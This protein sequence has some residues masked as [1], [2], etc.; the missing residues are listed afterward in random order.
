MSRKSPRYGRLG[1]SRWP[2]TGATFILV[3]KDQKNPETAKSV[4]KFFDWCYKNGQETAKQK[5]YVPM[6][7]SVVKMVEETWSKD[8]TSGGKP[9]WP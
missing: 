7:E 8:V 3:F 5:D 2:I 9:I 4:L 6:P 1:L